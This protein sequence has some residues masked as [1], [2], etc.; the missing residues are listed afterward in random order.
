MTQGISGDW[1]KSS[2]SSNNGSCVEVKLTGDLVAVRNS[3]HPDDGQVLFTRDEW[4]AFLPGVRDG[5][6]NL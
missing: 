6:F 2:Y 1:K 3:N 5:E 4:A